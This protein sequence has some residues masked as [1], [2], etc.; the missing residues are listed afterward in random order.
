MVYFM[1]SPYAMSG[2]FGFNDAEFEFI[3]QYMHNKKSIKTCAGSQFKL[4]ISHA[5]EIR[6]E[7]Q[8]FN[9]IKYSAYSES[10]SAGVFS[11]DADDL[12]SFQYS[13]QRYDLKFRY[14]NC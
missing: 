7:I 1:S 4:F 11:E 3:S 10:S 13:Y 14:K 6:K 2:E 12:E 5:A 9:L 8:I